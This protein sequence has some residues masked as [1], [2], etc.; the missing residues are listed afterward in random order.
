[1]WP[2]VLHFLSQHDR[3]RKRAIQMQRTVA[4]S[5]TSSDTS[6]VR[7][8]AHSYSHFSRIHKLRSQFT[9]V[10]VCECVVYRQG[11]TNVAILNR[12]KYPTVPRPAQLQDFLFGPGIKS[13]HPFQHK[14]PGERLSN[15]S[16]CN[17]CG[18]WG[19]LFSLNNKASDHNRQRL[20]IKG[21]QREGQLPLNTLRPGPKTCESEW[22]SEHKL[23]REQTAQPSG[24]DN[25]MEIQQEATNISLAYLFSQY[26]PLEAESITGD[27][28]AQ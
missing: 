23:V 22:R 19:H 26:D 13:L 2:R 7:P 16:E 3:W 25:Q 15:N 12:M 9:S 28:A 24:D 17:L 27:T 6:D 20:I 5:R 10:H 14:T 8:S 18:K 1:M 4:L 11:S 21:W